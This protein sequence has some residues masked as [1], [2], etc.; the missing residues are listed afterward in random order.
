LKLI[1]ATACHQT[2]C[3]EA[4][5]LFVRTE[6]IMPTPEATDAVERAIVKALRCKAKGGRR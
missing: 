4:G 1:E 6:D 5:V 3:F 2:A